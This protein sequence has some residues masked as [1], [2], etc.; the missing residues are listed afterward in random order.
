LE[1]AGAGRR[2]EGGEQ[3]VSRF[4]QGSLGFYLFQKHLQGEVSRP[5]KIFCRFL[6]NVGGRAGRL[7]SESV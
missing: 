2:F 6:K 3:T 5:E 4:L 7:A 1:L